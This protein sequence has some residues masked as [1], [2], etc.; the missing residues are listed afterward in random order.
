M[1]H[2]ALR[3]AASRAKRARWCRTRP[4]RSTSYSGGHADGDLRSVPADAGR[5]LSFARLQETARLAW[6]K[7]QAARAGRFPHNP[8]TMCVDRDFLRERSSTSRVSTG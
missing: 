7:G 1:A 3:L 8:T 6:P 2:L 5:R 4:I